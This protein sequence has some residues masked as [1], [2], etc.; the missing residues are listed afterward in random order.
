MPDSHPSYV[1][2]RAH[3]LSHIDK[4]ALP[5]VSGLPIMEQQG[6]WLPA[7]LVSLYFMYLWKTPILPL[8]SLKW[9]MVLGLAVFAFLVQKRS[10]NMHA[11]SLFWVV[12]GLGFFGA[13]L[14]LLRA[15]SL[16]LALWN[17][18]GLGISFVTYL[19]FIP[20]FATRLTRGILLFILIGAAVLWAVEIQRYVNA[21]GILIYATFSETGEDKNHIGF[22]LSLASTALLYLSIYWKPSRAWRKWL[23]FVIRLVFGLGAIYMFYSLSL[24]Y[25]RSGI[26]TTFVGIG[27]VLVVMFIKSPRR[28]RFLRVG[29]AVSIIVLVVMFLIPQ[30]L[31]VSPDW[32]SMYNRMLTEGGGAFYNREVLIRKGLYLVSQNPFLGVGA[33]GSRLAVTGYATFPGYLIHNS[34]LTDWAEKGLLGLLSNVVWIMAYFKMFRKKFLDLPLTDQIW[35]LLFIPL[36]FEMNFLDMSSISTTMLVILSGIYFE[37]YYIEQTR[38]TPL[39]PKTIGM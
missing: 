9:Y 14:S 21:H 29:M 17:T 7:I 30:V 36:F 28:S 25:A 2:H 27:A 11:A 5:Q 15:T 39:F 18:L 33:G 3:E 38:S 23:V 26:L 24:I 16:D 32:E 34:Y 13:T 8:V 20:T 31:A 37:Q 1:S 19:L 10:L 6:K 35:L 22:D 12:Y 4:Q